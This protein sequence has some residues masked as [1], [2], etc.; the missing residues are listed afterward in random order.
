MAISKFFVFILL[1]AINLSLPAPLS[2][3]SKKNGKVSIPIEKGGVEKGR[4]KRGQREGVWKSYNAKG[5]LIQ[6][7]RFV[8]G[9]RDGAMMRRDDSTVV[10]GYYTA[11][12]KNGAFIT[13]VNGH[14]V[15]EINYKIDTLHGKF[16][17]ETEEKDVA[18][19][20]DQGR[21]TGLWVIDSVDYQKKRIRDSTRYA[22]GL[23]DGLSVLYINRI[24]VSRTN[25]LA[26]KRN[27]AY[28][29]FDEQS[30]RMIT[31]G[32]YIDGERDG[33]WYEYQDGKLRSVEDFE[34]GIHAA[35]S[36]TYGSDTSIIIQIDTYY[37]DGAKKTLQQNDESGKLLHR[38]YYN[39]QDNIDSV[40]SYYPNGKIKS[41]QYTAYVN[42][43]GFTQFYLYMSYHP[44]G[45]LETRGFEY[46]TSRN[47]TWLSYDSTGKLTASVHYAENVPF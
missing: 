23:R 13:T 46:R 43:D 38:W 12:R 16:F 1:L 5:E 14:V 3:Q 19:T 41:G 22:N 30:G 20:Y 34:N 39:P 9:K 35:N 6:E 32:A 8:N 15:R 45:K 26:G 24:L 36:I 11:G 33:L 31:K 10:T 21:K 7:E 47:G 27:G 37:P 2:A 42:E 44:N 17:M 29:A 28:T 4:I 25:W 18:G 40:I